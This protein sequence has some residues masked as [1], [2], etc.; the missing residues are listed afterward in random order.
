[1]S[2]HIQ[3]ILTAK[4]F[5][6]LNFKGFDWSQADS[7]IFVKLDLQFV[8]KVSDHYRNFPFVDDLK[9][10]QWKYLI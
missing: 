2:R 9:C 10:F 4:S 1:M 8:P 6:P 5:N 3:K 7:G